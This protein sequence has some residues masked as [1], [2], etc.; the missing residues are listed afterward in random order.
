MG[1]ELRE[2]QNFYYSQVNTSPV[3]DTELINDRTGKCS[4]PGK[5]DKHLKIHQSALMNWETQNPKDLSLPY[6]IN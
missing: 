2:N 4:K 5:K 3:D 1:E 6:T